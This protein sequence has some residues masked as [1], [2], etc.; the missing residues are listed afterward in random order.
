MKRISLSILAAAL[1]VAPVRASAQA[2]LQRCD[3]SMADA[4][5]MVQTVM[6]CAGAGDVLSLA[7]ST[8]AAPATVEQVE[9]S[10]APM[11][12]VVDHAVR[13]HQPLAG[14]L[15]EYYTYTAFAAGDPALCAPLEYTS[16]A[17][18]C[19]QKVGKLLFLQTVTAPAPQFAKACVRSEGDRADAQTGRCCDLI[20]GVRGRPEACG[21]LLAQCQTGEPTCRAFALSAV[22]DASACAKI[23]VQSEDC[24]PK[25][26]GDCARNQAEDIAKCEGTA[27]YARAFKAKNISLCAGQYECRA[28]MGGAKGVAQEI[29]AKH[30]RNPAG[31]WFLTSGWKKRVRSGFKRVAVAAP[32]GA[33]AAAAPKVPAPFKG[34]ACTGVLSSLENRRAATA[35]INAAQVC[36]TDVEAALQ[37]PLRAVSDGIDERLE[38]LARLSLRLEKYFGTGSGKPAPAPA[39]AGR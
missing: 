17:R 21:P 22:G 25:V 9:Y 23:P 19:R 8:P 14:H 34:F 31:E 18:K 5:R 1:C 10:S 6:E 2:I 37:S 38:K 4:D 35:A 3:A 12:A 27:A 33:P 30:L 39:P 32:A 11:P 7:V 13:G 16:G 26:A 36:L 20:A 29:A 15:L 28:L 24:D